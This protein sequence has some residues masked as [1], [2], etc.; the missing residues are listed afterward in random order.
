MINIDVIRLSSRGQIV[1]PAKM[2]K[3]LNEGEEL[4]IIRD[5]SRII[6]KKAGALTENMKEDVEF[7]KRTEEALERWDKGEFVSMGRN[8]FLKELEQW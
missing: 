1:I 5:D 8:D 2:R 3:D 4:V 6:L 7:A